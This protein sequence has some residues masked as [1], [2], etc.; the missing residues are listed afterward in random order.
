M[1]ILCRF[2]LTL[3][4]NGTEN[5]FIFDKSSVVHIQFHT[6]NEHENSYYTVVKIELRNT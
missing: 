6:N 2:F 1:S 5:R 3:G 4:H